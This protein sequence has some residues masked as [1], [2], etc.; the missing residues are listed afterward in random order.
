MA[1][2]DERA[3]LQGNRHWRTAVWALRVGGLGLA[4]ALVGLIALSAGATPWVFAAGVIMWLVSA[5]V[6]LTGFLRAR[7]DL[8]EPR[9][10]FWSMRFTLIH[11]TVHARTPVAPR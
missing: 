9:P 1:D 8:P 2:M 4:V 7:R 6:T 11:D 10:G 3:E 5:A